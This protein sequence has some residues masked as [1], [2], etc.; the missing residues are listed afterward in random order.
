MFKTGKEKLLVVGEGSNL[1]NGI[2]NG[3]LQVWPKVEIVNYHED[4][5]DYAVY[6]QMNSLR[7]DFK[8]IDIVRSES[9]RAIKGVDPDIILNC[10]G[11]VNS[12]KCVNNELSALR[13]NYETAKAMFSLAVYCDAKVI[14]LGTTA[15]YVSP[16]PI[17]ED[18]PPALQQSAYSLTKLLGEQVIQ[19]LG[20]DA[21]IILPV[22]VY[23]G[24]WDNSS[25]ISSIIRRH[26]EG[27]QEHLTHNIDLLSKKVPIYIED[28]VDAVIALLQSDCRGRYVVGSP[29]SSVTYQKVLD[30]LEDNE[31]N[32][33]NI[34][35]MNYEDTLG[36][37]VPDVA[38]LMNDT[39][40]DSSWPCH[41][42]ASGIREQIRR[43]WWMYNS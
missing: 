37:H 33:K 27:S 13:A 1:A 28:F 43:L 29:E 35:F 11:L 39:V 8:E 4:V 31:I 41:T 25:V 36:N 21:L 9:Q 14:H 12:Y 42:L 20:D 26:L 40:L 38:K 19:Q 22:F 24:E 34:S 18:T 23:G 5:I 32:T 17:N 16:L 3:I 30:I 10:S 15:S 6:S 7:P 2:V